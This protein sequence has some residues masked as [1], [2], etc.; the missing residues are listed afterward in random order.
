M[1]HLPWHETCNLPRPARGYNRHVS[2]RRSIAV[3]VLQAPEPWICDG[4][5]RQRD[6]G[7]VDEGDSVG[8]AKLLRSVAEEDTPLAVVVQSTL[9]ARPVGSRPAEPTV[10]INGAVTARD[11]DIGGIGAR[12][13]RFELH[14]MSHARH[15][16]CDAV[17]LPHI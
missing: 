14:S 13:E 8:G 7:G 12:D 3:K 11:R 9:R 4:D 15:K 2:M 1:E 17:V 5:V 10:S 16:M 6:I